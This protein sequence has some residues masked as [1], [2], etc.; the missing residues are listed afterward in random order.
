M[1]TC[2]FVCKDTETWGSEEARIDASETEQSRGEGLGEP[3]RDKG[4][5]ERRTA[6]DKGKETQ[7]ME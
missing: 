2:A 1:R 3:G 5:M 6:E 7:R 4:D